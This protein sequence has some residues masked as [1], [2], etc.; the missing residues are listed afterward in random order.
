MDPHKPVDCR[1]VML[2]TAPYDN[3]AMA[4]QKSISAIERR[5]GGDRSW[6]AIEHRERQ[7]VAS[8]YHVEQ[9]A[10][11]AAPGIL[12]N[13]D[14]QICSEPDAAIAVTRH[15]IDVSDAPVA[16]VARVDGKMCRAVEL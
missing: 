5:T 7:A 15:K 9:Q 1:D 11:V 6:N 4:H 2:P 10:M 12:R 3:V 16:G 14:P 8:V 13:Q